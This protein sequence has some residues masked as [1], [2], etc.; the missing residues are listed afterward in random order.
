MTYQK[1]TKCFTPLIILLIS[2]FLFSCKEK[3]SS[4]KVEKS[5]VEKV[6]E[7]LDTILNRKPIP[8]KSFKSFED[9]A[10]ST[11]VRLADFSDG[12]AYDMRYATENN[13]LNAQVYDCAECYTRIKTVKA[14]LKANAEF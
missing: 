14:L 9:Y 6:G 11:F 13:F 7:A 5:A 2:I 8:E 12:F 3:S 4:E 10:D 1:L